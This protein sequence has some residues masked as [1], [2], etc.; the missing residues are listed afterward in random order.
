MSKSGDTV[1]FNMQMDRVLK[2]RLELYCERTGR[3]MTSVVTLVLTQFLDNADGMGR[4]SSG[5]RPIS[6]R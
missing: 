2:K 4:S 5:K 6:R 1:A 3:T